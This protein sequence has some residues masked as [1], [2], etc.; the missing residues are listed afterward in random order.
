M[1]TKS[2]AS[3]LPYR[4]GWFIP[5]VVIPFVIVLAVLMGWY[6]RIST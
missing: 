3:D 1:S 4:E 2:H 6:V 5:P